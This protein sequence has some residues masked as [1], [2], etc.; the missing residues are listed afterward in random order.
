MN[1]PEKTLKRTLKV[2]SRF[3][4]PTYGKAAT[5]P[6]IRLM[7]KWLEKW[8]FKVGNNISVMKTQG[9]M[10][11]TNLNQPPIHIIL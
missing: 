11:I 6:E 4:I 2:Y 5:L 3:I 7:G 9:G 10:L 1:P 8:G